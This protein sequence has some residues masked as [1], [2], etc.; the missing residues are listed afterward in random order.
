MTIKDANAQHMRATVEI[1]KWIRTKRQQIRNEETLVAAMSKR[2]TIEESGALYRLARPVLKRYERHLEETNTVDHE[3][4][5]LKAC[6]YLRTGKA[7]SAV[8]SDPGRRVPG[9]EPSPRAFLHA[10]LAPTDPGRPSTRPRSRQ[11]A[12]TGRR[13]SVF[14][15]ETS[16]SC[17]SSTIPPTRTKGRWSGSNSNK[18]TVWP[19]NCRLDETV[20]HSRERSDRTRSDRGPGDDTRPSVA[21]KHRHGIVEAHA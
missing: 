9:R 4:T 12:T 8:E 2:G 14:R 3:E 17:V 19:S 6:R 21:L 20:R 16:T 10:L 1:D 15:A 7:T 13:S 18:A 5:I 11:S